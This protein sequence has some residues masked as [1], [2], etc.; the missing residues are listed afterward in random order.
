MEL[1]VLFAVMMYGIP[2]MFLPFATHGHRL[3][4]RAA[5]SGFFIPP[6]VGNVALLLQS[7]GEDVTNPGTT[8]FWIFI[9]ASYPFAIFPIGLWGALL[10]AAMVAVVEK[11]L[12]YINFPSW[13]IVVSG[14]LC[15]CLIGGVFILLLGA[16]LMSINGAQGEDGGAWLVAGLAGGAASG[17]V[18]SLFWLRHEQLQQSG[19]PNKT[20]AHS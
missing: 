10:G 11:P 19:S 7:H 20:L 14:I 15:G 1:Q 17:L 16:V 18:T 13:G 8:S 12:R 4:R 3:R 9:G 5:L 6:L 2:L